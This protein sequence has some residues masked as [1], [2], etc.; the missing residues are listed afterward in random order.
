MLLSK[1]I[2]VFLGYSLLLRKLQETGLPIKQNVLPQTT[3]EVDDQNKISKW[4][5]VLS[6]KKKKTHQNLKEMYQLGKLII[7]LTC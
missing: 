7:F 1:Y 4:K 6:K 5:I 3:P 2:S